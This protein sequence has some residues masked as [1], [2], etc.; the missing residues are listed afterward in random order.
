MIWI[1]QGKTRIERVSASLFLL[2]QGTD[3]IKDKDYERMKHNSFF[4][5]YYMTWLSKQSQLES[6]LK[7]R[8]KDI[9]PSCEGFC[10]LGNYYME[11]YKFI[12]A[13][14]YYRWASY[15][16]PTRI[17]PQYLLW[18]LYIITGEKEKA[19]RVAH[20]I[21]EMPLKVEN[22]YTL[23]IKRRMKEYLSQKH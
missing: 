19:R 7:K 10:H 23:K 5:D 13:K 1:I 9:L 2:Y 22:T 4:N 8:I 3:T 6:H 21:I 11:Q 16:I 17:R 15:M 12:Q 20:T 18:Q 14:Y